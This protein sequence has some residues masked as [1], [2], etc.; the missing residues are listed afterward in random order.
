MFYDKCQFV[1]LSLDT[2]NK[3]SFVML[4]SQAQ[5]HFYAN[6]EFIVLFDDFCQKIQLFF[7]SLEWKYFNLIKWPKIRLVDTIT[8]NL[9]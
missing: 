9:T 8:A 1:D 4:T 7:E 6:S 5:T 3:N 2:H